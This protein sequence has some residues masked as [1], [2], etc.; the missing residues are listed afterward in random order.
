MP[1]VRRIT[2]TVRGND[3]NVTLPGMQWHPHR[4]PCYR[5]SAVRKTL[6]MRRGRRIKGEP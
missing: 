2:I 1:A 6:V 3:A 4:K 5:S